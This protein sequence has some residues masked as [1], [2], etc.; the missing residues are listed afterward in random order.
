YDDLA[1]EVAVLEG[2]LTAAT[3]DPKAIDAAAHKLRGSLPEVS[4][5]GDLGALDT[6]LAGILEGVDRRLAEHAEARAQAAA[7]AVEAKRAAV[8]GPDGRVEDGRS[9]RT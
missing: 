9:C 2:R 1:A 8:Q 5:I 4:V 3:A 6:R 7:A